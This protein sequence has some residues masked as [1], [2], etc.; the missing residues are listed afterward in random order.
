MDPLSDAKCI[1]IIFKKKDR[2]VD[3]PPPP[4]QL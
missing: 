3:I 2:P 4:L 1:I